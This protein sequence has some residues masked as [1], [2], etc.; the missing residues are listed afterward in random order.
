M[1]LS[2]Q[3]EKFAKAIALDGMSQ[4]DAFRAAYKCDNWTDKSIYE[5]ASYLANK[6]V[7]IKS[8]IAELRREVDTPRI[9]S[10]QKRKEKL[11]EIVNTSPD[12][13]VVMKAIDLLNK[14]DGE[15]TTKV[16]ANVNSEVNITV[17]LVD[18]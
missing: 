18:G 13:N 3:Q 8:R 17:E 1:G 6:N 15:Y 10:A 16:E 14:M 12:I 9:M 4:C 5:K 11:T 2:P 7:K